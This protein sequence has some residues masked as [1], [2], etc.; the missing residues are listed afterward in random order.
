M[1]PLVADA[2]FIQHVL[3]PNIELCAACQK[4]R[5]Q[6]R[7]FVNGHGARSCPVVGRNPTDV[8]KRVMGSRKR[9]I[10]R[11]AKRRQQ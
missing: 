1:P 3:D 5:K 7:M 4:P 10:Q 8:E 2:E 9:Q 6:D 11:A